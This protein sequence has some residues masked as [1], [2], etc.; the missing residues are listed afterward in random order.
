MIALIANSPQSLIAVY[1]SAP[2][3]LGLPNGEQ[4]SGADL[5]WTSQDGAYSLVAVAPFVVPNGYAA[6]G[7]ASYAL[8]GG[9]V[10][11]TYATQAIAAPTAQQ[12]AL[13]AYAAAI[14][15]GVVV[16]ST[17]TPA[18]NATYACDSGAQDNLSA[19]ITGIAAGLGLPGGGPTLVYLDAASA[20]HVFTQAQ[21]ATL[22]VAI[23]NYVYALD[24]FAAGQGSMPSN[25]VNIS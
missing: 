16:T 20:P 3:P 22:A 12:L 18:L 21:F 15:A 1:P 13:A 2:D 19:I 24:L 25:T 23:R 8:V 4:V 6:L 17:A 7:A 5:G 14:S 10:T 9:V 11:Q